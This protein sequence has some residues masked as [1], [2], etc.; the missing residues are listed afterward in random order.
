MFQK[1]KFEIK[2]TLQKKSKRVKKV[3]ENFCKKE[4]KT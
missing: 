4:L 1:I 2:K 3:R